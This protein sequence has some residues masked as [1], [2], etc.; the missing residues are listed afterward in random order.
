MPT[1]TSFTSVAFDDVTLPKV[2]W[3]GK[4]T[5]EPHHALSLVN[6]CS[7][8]I[9][10]GGSSRMSLPFT[11]ER[12]EA[13]FHLRSHFPAFRKDLVSQVSDKGSLEVLFDI[14]E[15]YIDPEWVL[16]EKAHAPTEV[17]AVFSI[18]GSAR[19]IVC[20]PVEALDHLDRV[21]GYKQL[22]FNPE[23]KFSV[24]NL[25]ADYINEMLPQIL[26]FEID[27]EQIHV[28]QVMAMTHL[29]AEHRMHILQK[30]DLL[31]DP[32]AQEAAQIIRFYL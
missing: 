2:G 15:Y 10:G 1:L 32:K 18:A 14:G 8:V 20:T 24:E 3:T 5:L 11:V 28:S 19:F 25:P 4:L 7:G 17:K 29:I 27:V 22:K 23:S 31:G 16:R 9:L 6:T 30:L 12:D 26:H 13:G 21:R